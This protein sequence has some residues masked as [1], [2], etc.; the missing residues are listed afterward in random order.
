VL[1]GD[2]GDW[3]VPSDLKRYRASNARWSLAQCDDFVNQA[4]IYQV[5]VLSR[6]NKIDILVDGNHEQT[7]LGRHHVDVVA[8]LAARLPGRPVLGGMSGFLRYNLRRA[9]NNGVASLTVAYHHGFSGSGKPFTPATINWFGSEIEDWDVGFV[10]HNHKKGEYDMPVM[11]PAKSGKPIARMRKLVGCGTHLRNYRGHRAAGY[12]ERSG[13]SVT[14]IGAPLVR[15]IYRH[16]EGS[17]HQ[18]EKLRENNQPSSW[19]EFEVIQ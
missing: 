14:S 3:I 12:S 18:R 1:G 5:A 4:L 9:N 19:I 11:R 7:I 10:G 2:I 17:H 15:W 13:H 8:E 16:A 6:C